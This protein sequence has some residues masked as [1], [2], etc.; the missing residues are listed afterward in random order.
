LIDIY[1]PYVKDITKLQAYGV[2]AYSIASE[3]LGSFF[4]TDA[5]VYISAYAYT[6]FVLKTCKNEILKNL[7]YNIAVPTC[8]DFIAKYI[9]PVF[10][11]DKNITELNN[12]NTIA[13]KLLLSSDL[14]TK[15]I[16]N[17]KYHK[18]IAGLAFKVCKLSSISQISSISYKEDCFNDI[19]NEIDTEFANIRNIMQQEASKSDVDERI[20]TFSLN[21]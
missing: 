14:Y 19:A 16:G 8:G 6:P 5:A 9:D 4:D 11:S 13:Y 20:S 10:T 18:I 7:E 3:L 17:D 1:F 21:L 2:M 15:Y 12:I